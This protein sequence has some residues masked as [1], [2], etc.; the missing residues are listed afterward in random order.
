MFLR[1]NELRERISEPN[2]NYISLT[3]LFVTTPPTLPQFILCWRFSIVNWSFCLQNTAQ[4]TQQT[5]DLRI[6]RMKE[7]FKKL[8]SK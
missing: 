6:V 1:E 2:Y 8:I 4:S 5:N 3:V 7:T